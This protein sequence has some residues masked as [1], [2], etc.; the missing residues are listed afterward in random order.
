MSSGVTKNS[1]T[2]AP[3]RAL[4]PELRD[5]APPHFNSP[6]SSLWLCPSLPFYLCS[7][8]WIG[9]SQ[10]TYFN[11]WR[12]GPPGR[13]TNRPT[14]QVPGGPV[15]RCIYTRT[16][17]NARIHRLHSSMKISPKFSIKGTY[18][19]GPTT[20]LMPAPLKKFPVNSLLQLAV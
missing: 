9:L 3:N 15:R 5:L 18:K 10:L 19:G 6:L 8:S 1:G 2:P 20:G 4:P 17:M 11:I 12:G 13:R 14:W 7:V 16:T